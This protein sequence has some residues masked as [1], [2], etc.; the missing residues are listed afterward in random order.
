MVRR[1]VT[2]VGC[3]V[4]VLWIAVGLAKD[5]GFTRGFERGI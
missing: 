3:D 2:L 4:V 5:F 1:D